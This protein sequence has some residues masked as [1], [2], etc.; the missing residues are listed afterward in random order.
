M[1]DEQDRDLALE[2]RDGGVKLLRDSKKFIAERNKTRKGRATNRGQR[3]IEFRA[4]MTES[5]LTPVARERLRHR[6][7]K[8]RN[9]LSV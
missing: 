3:R 2:P 1:R 6:A 7:E 5:T 4:R 9:V 8:I